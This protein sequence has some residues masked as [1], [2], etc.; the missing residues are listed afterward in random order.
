MRVPV[1][2]SMTANAAGAR[3]GA[4]CTYRSLAVISNI[5]INIIMII[6]NNIV[7][8]IIIK[9]PHRCSWRQWFV[10]VIEMKRRAT[11]LER[12]YYYHL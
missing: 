3:V 11:P 6:N 10:C 5:I 4:L 9:Q 1:V 8:I 2:L 7:I 12:N